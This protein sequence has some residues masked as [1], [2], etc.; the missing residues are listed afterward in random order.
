M[1]EFINYGLAIIFF[2]LVLLAFGLLISDSKEERSYGLFVV[3]VMLFVFTIY[4]DPTVRHNDANKNI[5][6]FKH[7]KNIECS[8]TW[9]K[10]LVNQKDWKLEGFYFIKNDGGLTIR[11]DKCMEK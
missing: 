10:Y 6:L 4:I 7:Q 2:V 5:D 3:P 8:T 1:S 11:A 9:E